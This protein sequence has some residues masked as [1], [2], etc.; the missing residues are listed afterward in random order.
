ML[1]AIK[2]L[3]EIVEKYSKEKFAFAMVSDKVKGGGL[4][5]K[6]VSGDYGYLLII[7]FDTTENRVE[8]K[9]I[10]EIDERV[11][12]EFLWLGNVRGN[13]P[14]NRLTTDNLE[15]IFSG[16]LF[17]LY[18]DLKE[19]VFKNKLK[20]IID[21]FYIKIN[22]SYFL[23]IS[24]IENLKIDEQS[25]KEEVNKLINQNLSLTDLK[26]K[27]VKALKELFFKNLKNIYPDYKERDF[28]LYSITIDDKTPS[29][30]DEY[31]NF[32]EEKLIE[33]QFSDSATIGH[34]YVCGKKEKLTYDTTQ[35]LDKFYVLK[36]ITFSSNLNNKNFY[37][38]FSLCKD[39]YR[40]IL[41]GSRF[42]NNH[43]NFS[44]FRTNFYLIPTFIIKPE[45]FELILSQFIEPLK[46]DLNS[47]NTIDNYIRFEKDKE[48]WLKDYEKYL[49]MKNYTF[50]TFLFYERDQQAFKIQKL[51]KDI[52][53]KRIDELRNLLEEINNFGNENLGKDDR[54]W[55]LS[56]DHIFNFFPIRIDKKRNAVGQRKILEIYERILNKFKIDY[57]FLINEFNEMARVYYYSNKNTQ[58]RIPNNKRYLE[59]DM[60]KSILRSNLF[61]KFLKKLNLI[62]GGEEVNLNLDEYPLNEILKN[63]IKGMDFDEQ[64]ISMF[65][66]GYLIGEIG[67]EQE[68][69]GASKKP[70]LDKLNYYGMNLNKI[71]ILTNEVF[72]KL[73]Q[74]R[75]RQDNEGIFHTMKSLLDKNINNWKL[76]DSENVYYI[77][78]GYAFSTNLNFI[79][80]GMKDE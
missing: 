70:I 65:L 58:I 68:N 51:I 32:I 2:N 41:I 15:Y 26:K 34:C 53:S 39:C 47:I 42:L 25:L 10:I 27:F 57:Y 20:S 50:L 19:G 36:F 54:Y 7:N 33:E 22:S 21:N 6:D 49:D 16:N 63:Y 62:D 55:I 1:E 45:K 11:K 46:D 44:L 12:R 38:N 71:L 74:Y 28:G 5:A 59:I 9:S 79:K 31:V 14:Q 80:G 29:E 72:D 24:K 13:A 48:R 30:I 75:I 43:L 67:K 52:P 3:G 23:N 78:S 35:F 8:I 64:K 60:V 4:S 37:K 17:N 18:K 40:Y 61:L 66:L 56:F 73:N 77:L 69:S 76:K